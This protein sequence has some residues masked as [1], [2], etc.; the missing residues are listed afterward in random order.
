MP[1]HAMRELMGGLHHL[2]R[3]QLH[4]QLFAALPE[5]LDSFFEGIGVLCVP[6]HMSAHVTIRKRNECLP[7]QAFDKLSDQVLHSGVLLVALQKR[8]LC[9]CVRDV[10]PCILI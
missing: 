4:L 6:V 10:R 7:A 8:L 3:L 5:G 2:L 1:G 9:Q